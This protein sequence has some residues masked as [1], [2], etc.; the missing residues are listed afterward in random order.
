VFEDEEITNILLLALPDGD[1]PV[2]PSNAIEFRKLPSTWAMEDCTYFH[3]VA[4]SPNPSTIFGIY[5]YPMSTHR[6]NSF[7][8]INGQR[9]GRDPVHGSEGCYRTGVSACLACSV[10][11]RRRALVSTGP[12]QV[13][14]ITSGDFARSSSSIPLSSTIWLPT[15]GR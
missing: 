15:T 1:H 8:S 12:R 13:L 5:A 11:Y 7:F 6:A 3:L 2:R 14:A 9:C 10:D 4:S